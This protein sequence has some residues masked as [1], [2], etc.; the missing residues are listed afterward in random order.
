MCVKIGMKLQ[1][2]LK[3]VMQ[4]TLKLPNIALLTDLIIIK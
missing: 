3:F 1:N 2:V 4:I